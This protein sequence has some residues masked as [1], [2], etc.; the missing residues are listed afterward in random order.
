MPSPAMAQ[1]FTPPLP[2]VTPAM[3]QALPPPPSLPRHPLPVVP[4]PTDPAVPK[5]KVWVIELIARTP[6]WTFAVL[7]GGKAWSLTRTQLRRDYPDE[8]FN[9]LVEQTLGGFP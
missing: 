9:F 7:I 8:Y 4:P 3:V 6:E 5:P 2:I 1:T